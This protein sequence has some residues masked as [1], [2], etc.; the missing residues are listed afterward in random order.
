MLR[1]LVRLISLSASALVLFSYSIGFPPPKKLYSNQSFREVNRK[2]TLRNFSLNKSLYRTI[3]KEQ[4]IN[5]Y[6]RNLLPGQ[7]S[8]S[9]SRLKHI[10]YYNPF[11]NSNFVSGRKRFD[12]CPQDKCYLSHD[13]SELKDITSWDAVVFTSAIKGKYHEGFS[14]YHLAF[15]P[16][17]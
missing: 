3:S 6:K 14:C 8:I 17:L 15:W 5:V 2:F 1:S 12:G 10:L 16:W 7:D 9:G 11:N 13:A 4:S